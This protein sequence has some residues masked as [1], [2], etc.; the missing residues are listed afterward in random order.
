M[1][2]IRSTPRPAMAGVS[3]DYLGEGSTHQ[4]VDRKVTIED[5]LNGA[6]K[7]D[8]QVLENEVSG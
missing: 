1:T 8:E 7:N 3:S 4:E 2:L 5:G 6:L